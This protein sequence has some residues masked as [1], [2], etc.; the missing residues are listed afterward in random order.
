MAKA[1]RRAARGRA[2]QGKRCAVGGSDTDEERA[3]WQRVTQ[4]R[5]GPQMTCILVTHWKTEEVQAAALSLPPRLPLCLH[6]SSPKA[7]AV[8]PTTARSAVPPHTGNMVRSFPSLLPLSRTL[9]SASSSS[10]SPPARASR[11]LGARASLVR[12]VRALAAGLLAPARVVTRA[13][14]LAAVAL[15]RTRHDD[16]EKKNEERRRTKRTK[17]RECQKEG[18]GGHSG[19]QGVRAVTATRFQC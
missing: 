2:R 3:E 8:P 1:T 18:A 14:R 16:L 9:P 11:V 7:A 19:Q 17:M 15:A 13:G 4:P 10:S 5:A 6:Q 12:A